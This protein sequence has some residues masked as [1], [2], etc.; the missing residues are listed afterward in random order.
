MVRHSGGSAVSVP[1]LVGV[2][3]R[4]EVQPEHTTGDGSAK[5]GRV[6]DKAGGAFLVTN[7]GSHDDEQGEHGQEDDDDCEG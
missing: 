7:P 2:I 5:A 4:L 3:W 1:A 6:A